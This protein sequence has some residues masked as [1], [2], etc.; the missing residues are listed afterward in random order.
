MPARIDPGVLQKVALERP[1][2]ILYRRSS[3]LFWVST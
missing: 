3:N 2:K 1:L